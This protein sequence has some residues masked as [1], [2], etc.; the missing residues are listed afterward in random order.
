MHSIAS[1]STK[2][3]SQPATQD[4]SKRP[5][6]RKRSRM[7]TDDLEIAQQRIRELEAALA[8]TMQELSKSEEVRMS[9]DTIIS[10]MDAKVLHLTQ[11]KVS[12]KSEKVKQLLGQLDNHFSCA[13]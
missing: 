1:G 8:K 10:E 12:N 9:R 11:E 7:E 3:N 13:L 5:L 6:K 2:V 4:G